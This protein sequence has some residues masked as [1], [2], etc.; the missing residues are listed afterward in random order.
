[1]T[2]LIYVPAAPSL[3]ATVISVLDEK[4]R[5]TAEEVVATQEPI[6]AWRI[7]R[8]AGYEAFDFAR[9]VLTQ[10]H[11]YD[12]DG[13]TCWVLMPMA[14][15]FY[16]LHSNALTDRYDSLE[17]AREHALRRAQ[18]LWDEKNAPKAAVS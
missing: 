9:P 2:K 4:G 16:C 8:A 7:E 14:Q 1:M 12:A 15:G 13:S 5:P 3:E 17:N 10:S 6:V 18:F 11:A